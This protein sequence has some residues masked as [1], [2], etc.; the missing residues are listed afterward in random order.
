MEIRKTYNIP[1]F[2]IE[3][4]SLDDSATYSLLSSGNTEG[5]FQF[6][7]EGMRKFCREIELSSFEEIVA[8]IALY[9]PFS[10]QLISQYINGKNNPSKINVPHPLLKD[11]LKETHGVLVYQEQVMSTIQIIAGYTLG[12]ADIM[13]RAMGKKNVDIMKKQ[14]ALF[15]ERAKIFNNINEKDALEIFVFLEKYS[16]HAFN[17]SHTVAFA[18]LSHRMAYLK[19]NYSTEFM[20]A[21]RAVYEKYNHL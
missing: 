21:V 5:I 14:K 11:L 20:S 10:I 4:I 9:R 16:R 19:A 18:I 2:N 3:E 17:K 12:E 15:V 8:L 13:C 7:S 6:E 1:D